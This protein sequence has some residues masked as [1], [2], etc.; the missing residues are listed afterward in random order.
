MNLKKFNHRMQK[1]A[2]KGTKNVEAMQ[3]LIWNV[4]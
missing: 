3:Y 1:M 2:K 4:Q